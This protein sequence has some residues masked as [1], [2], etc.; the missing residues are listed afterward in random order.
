[1][2]DRIY[3]FVIYFI[4]KIFQNKVILI[5]IKKKKKCF[6]DSFITNFR[7]SNFRLNNHILKILQSKCMLLY[8]IIYYNFEVI[9]L[10]LEI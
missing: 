6:Q 7:I 1:M 2:K 10:I 4:K 9:F 5:S 3:I 8:F